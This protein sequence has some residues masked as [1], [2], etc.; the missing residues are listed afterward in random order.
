MEHHNPGPGS[1]GA[2]PVPS[3][4]AHWNPCLGH[5]TGRPAVT[6]QGPRRTPQIAPALPATMVQDGPTIAAAMQ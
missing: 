6:P 2:R 3:E 5:W 4:T 1:T